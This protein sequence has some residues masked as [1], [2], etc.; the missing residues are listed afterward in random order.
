[1]ADRRPTFVI[2]GANLTGG[3]A[4]ST[5]RD[6]GFDGR[7]VLIGDEIHPPYERP[8]LS[9]GYLRGQESFDDALLRPR[10]W[11]EQNDVE[12]LLDTTASRI[13]P[14]DRVVELSA[15][16]RIPYDKVLVATGGRNRRLPVP[17][18]D[19]EGVLYLR[20][21]EDSDA[22]RSE[23]QPG[24]K[25]A[26]V[27]AGFIGCEVAASLRTVGVEVEVVE[28]F[29]FPLVRVV[30]PELGR[31]YESIHRDHGVR[32]HFDESVERFEG[33]GRVEAVVTSKGNRIECDFAVVGVGIRPAT[34]VVEGSAVE[35]GNGIMVDQFCRTTVED[36][37]AAG[38]VANHD[39]P[40]FRRQMRVEHWDNALKQGAAA[41]RNMM[42]TETP[43]A[44]PHW[45]WS[46]QY[47]VNLQYMGFATEWDELVVRGSLEDR[48]F[49]GFYVKDGIVDAV[50]G[51]NR[52]REVRR[53]AGLIQSRRPVDTA[54]LRDEDVELKKLS[55]SLS[56]QGA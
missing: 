18:G 11:Y 3:A 47:D 29:E 30:G 28:I 17:G 16:N 5:L 14:T 13:D 7:I 40:L 2:V 25:A 20:T 45:F 4:V 32:F 12:L 21:V 19:L 10:D 15:G 35:V 56:Q 31:V 44:D 22:I 50:V 6:Q 24:R 54:V 34:D 42:G 51:M 26:V 53:S 46:D 55:Q 39:H 48:N 23:A 33:T 27:G 49:V 52:G 36:V 37:Y 43:F 9:K 41:A 38:D 1:M 8:P